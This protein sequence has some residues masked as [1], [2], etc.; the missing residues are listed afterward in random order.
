MVF[1]RAEPKRVPGSPAVGHHEAE[2]KTA[3][4]MHECMV[5]RLHAA[6][7][8]QKSLRLQ[9]LHS[10][11]HRNRRSG[12]RHGHAKAHRHRVRNFPRHL[13]Q[14]APSLEAEDAAPYAIETHRN[15]RRLNA[16]HNALKPAPEG[17]QL[18]R[19]RDLSFGKDAYDLVLPQ[20]F[21][22]RAQRANHVPRPLL[23]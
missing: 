11:P 22:C 4:G 1:V 10:A 9:L 13:P 8:L 18:S 14:E 7:A 5:Q 3:R 15:N 19:A 20:R 2:G 21:C 17:Q 6:L 16:L 12:R 23:A